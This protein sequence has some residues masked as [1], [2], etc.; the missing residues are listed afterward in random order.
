MKPGWLLL[1][2]GV[3]SVVVVGVLLLYAVVSLSA[4]LILL[5]VVVAV[6][7]G[8]LGLGIG[9]LMLERTR[10]LDQDT[11]LGGRCRTCGYSL[12]GLEEREPGRVDCPE[13]GARWWLRG[14][15]NTVRVEHEACRECGYSLRGLVADGAG[16]LACPE[17]GAE[18]WVERID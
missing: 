8:L 7:L 6:L 12:H 10:H 2:Y 11:P 13:C 9:V 14:A 18:W 4:A 3:G 5:S 16:R 17:C 1:A 15:E